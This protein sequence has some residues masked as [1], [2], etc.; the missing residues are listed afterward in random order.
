MKPK[1]LLKLTFFCLTLIWMQGCGSGN[2]SLDPDLSAKLQQIVDQ[3]KSEF[4]IPG[5]L[6]G[7]WIP[8]KGS[9]I[10]EDGVADLSTSEPISQS[11]HFRIGSITKSFTVT[12]ILQLAEEGRLGLNDTLD[13]YLPGIENGNATL[14][15]L[16]NM[17][18]GIFNYT[19]DPDFVNVFVMDFKKKWTDQEIVDY[20]DANAPYFPPGEGWHYSNTNTILLGMV[21]EQVTGK[22]LGDVIQERIIAP[23]SLDG[24][25]Y[26][27]SPD[28][29]SPFVHGYGFDPLE[30]ISF[31][32][33]SS[34][35]GSGAI[36]STLMG[37]KKWGEALGTGALLNQASQ[38]ERL[39]SLEPI[40]SDP[41]DDQDPTRSKKVCPDY[42]RYGYGFGE[43]N[44]WIGHTGELI[45]YTSLVMYQPSSGSV[46]VILT[47]IFGLG[48]HVPTA[49]FREFAKIL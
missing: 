6:V 34:S 5:V 40:V 27:T 37:L 23:L 42:D 44:G 19:E 13:S 24:T 2:G 31:T 35:S 18:S 41:C 12:V 49:M 47:N 25:L 29:P 38:T 48:E 4:G 36:I 39:Q 16:A 8:K 45:G 14:A 43:I 11:Q 22:P 7:V 20:A 17:R 1:I 9:L 30:D 26:P 28:L 33:P 10:I 3:K 21:V 15:Q 46:V 32:D